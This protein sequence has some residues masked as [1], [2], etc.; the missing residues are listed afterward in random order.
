MSSALPLI[1]KITATAVDVPLARPIKTSVGTI[2][3]SPLVLI[4]VV[5]AHDIVGR[6]YIF[7][8]TPVTLRPLVALLEN[9]EALLVGK[10]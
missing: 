7:G 8:Y 3:S 9:L 2:P 4:E 10:S 1:E 5:A 6:S